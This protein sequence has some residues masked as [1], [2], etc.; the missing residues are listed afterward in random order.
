MLSIF[1]NLLI[2]TNSSPS[3]RS[4]SVWNDV[5][6]SFYWTWSQI[7]NCS[8]LIWRASCS[9]KQTLSDYDQKL[10]PYVMTNQHLHFNA[11]ENARLCSFTKEEEFKTNNSHLLVVNF[12]F[13]FPLILIVSY[14]YH[15]NKIILQRSKLTFLKSRLLA[16][17]N[18][19]MPNS[20]L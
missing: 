3:S 18:P 17:F 12:A 2:L 5:Q 6:T 1:A 20:D 11:E 15:T 10:Y 13:L 9:G 16:T 14:Q 19:L 8:V 7:S 4:S